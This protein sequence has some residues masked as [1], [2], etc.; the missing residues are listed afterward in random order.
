ML[1]CL[2]QIGGL[3]I[4]LIR[5]NNILLAACYGTIAASFAIEQIGMPFLTSS[6]QDNEL[7]NGEIVQNRLELYIQR[8]RELG[9]KLDCTN[10]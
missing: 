4:G 7:W 5:T 9:I 2:A 8:V 3:A 1:T 10:L 6:E